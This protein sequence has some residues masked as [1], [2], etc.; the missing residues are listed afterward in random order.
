MFKDILFSIFGYLGVTAIILA[1]ILVILQLANRIF[2][3]SK[4]IIMYQYYKKDKELYVNRNNL[5]INKN[6]KILYS[7]NV[8]KADEQIEVLE[9]SIDYI[10]NMKY[11]KIS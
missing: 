8:M 1:L 4:Y 6:G 10:N 9:K 7:C 11:L 2:K 5:I 3:I